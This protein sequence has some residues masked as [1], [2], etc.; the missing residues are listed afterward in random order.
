MRRPER[1]RFIEGIGVDRMGSIADASSSDMLRLENLD[2]DI[3]PDPAVL[4]R[5]R[6]S[7]L[8]DAANSYLPFV[9]Q[10]NLREAAAQHLTR[11]TGVAYTADNVIIS[12]GGLSGVLNTL[13]ATIEIGDEVLVTDPTYAGLLNRIRLVGGVPIPV[14]FDFRP[15]DEW[16]LDRAGLA[17]AITPK[18]RAM[19]LMSPS[20]PSGGVL[21]RGDWEAVAKLC[22]EHDLLLIVDAAMERLLFG[23]REVIHPASFDGMAAR[24]ISVGA[25]SKELRMIGWRVGWIVAP[26][27][28]VPDIV[29]V[30]L[31]NVVVPVGIAQDAAAVGLQSAA[32]T[33]PP[34]VAELERRADLIATEL[35]GL[36]FGRPSGGWSMLLRVR[37]YGLTGAQMARNLLRVG[38]CATSMAGWGQTHGEDFIRFVFA[39]EPVDRLR[40]LRAKIDAALEMG[41]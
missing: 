23:Q 31:A 8:E 30:S 18:T 38:V 34:Y 27:A 33:L 5:T 25:A 20:M 21:E 14:K 41:K 24:T 6:Q 12:A 22:T 1:L 7:V 37:D 10:K 35:D 28:F 4:E 32:T 16:R 9:G 3:L 29:S 26:E 2:T 39:N 40:G 13:L 15:G 19:L 17:A 11:T 36:P